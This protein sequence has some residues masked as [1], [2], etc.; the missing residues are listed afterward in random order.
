M[1][2]PFSNPKGFV[3]CRQWSG[4]HRVVRSLLTHYCLVGTHL[5]MSMDGSRVRFS[6]IVFRFI[7]SSISF[8]HLSGYFLVPLSCICCTGHALEPD[9][10]SVLDK[11]SR[12]V[13]SLLHG[14]SKAK[15]SVFLGPTD[16]LPL[17]GFSGVLKFFR[18]G[19]APFEL[20]ESGGSNRRQKHKSHLVER[21][22]HV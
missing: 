5:D 7:C 9:T 10:S 18:R 19:V 11:L 8:F 16:L 2:F 13:R 20:A 14:S 3:G 15:P 22:G 12:N 6:P 17:R 4:R 21:S 1:H